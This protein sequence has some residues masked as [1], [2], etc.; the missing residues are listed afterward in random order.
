MKK[1]LPKSSRGSRSASRR[2]R[3]RHEPDRAAGAGRLGRPGSRLRGAGP[4]R[5]I[6]ELDGPA[7]SV[8]ALDEGGA[9]VGWRRRRPRL[10]LGCYTGSTTV[11]VEASNFVSELAGNG[12]IDPSFQAAHCRD[13]EVY[14]IARQAD[15]KVVAAG[16]RVVRDGRF[17]RLAGIPPRQRGRWMRASRPG[18][19]ELPSVD[20][21][22]VHWGQWIA[23]DPTGE[24]QSRASRNRRG[25][26]ARRANCSS[27]ACRRTE[28]ST[29][30]S[31]PRAHTSALPWLIQ[32]R[33]GRCG[34]L[35]GDYRVAAATASGCAI[36]GSPPRRAGRAF[37]AAGIAPVESAPGESGDLSLV[38]IAD[39]WKHLVA[40]NAGGTDSRHACSQ[41]RARHRLRA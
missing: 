10:P 24:S 31:V 12:S 13:I 2:D 26:C 21:G 17:I 5:P 39:R 29:N 16:R 28:A 3:G 18:L 27:C 33:P 30:R 20:Y 7:W 8:L 38:H 35:K 23:L 32:P 11:D 4:T 36:V 1:P 40:G 25:R 41:R 34:P 15:G 14:D 37:G 6:P 19:F 9:L 22:S